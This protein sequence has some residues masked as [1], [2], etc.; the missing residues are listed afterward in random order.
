VTAQI[1]ILPQN[2]SFEPNTGQDYTFKGNRWNVVSVKL[3]P[4]DSLW[5]ITVGR[6]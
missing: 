6:M 3:S 2:I 1:M 4:Q 5:E